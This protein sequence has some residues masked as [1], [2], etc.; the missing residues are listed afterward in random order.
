MT[1]CFWRASKHSESEISEG[2]SSRHAVDG[3]SDSIGGPKLRRHKDG[4]GPVTRTRPAFQRHT[5]GTRCC[6][7]A[8]SCL[9]RPSDGRS[10][11]RRNGF[12]ASWTSSGTHGTPQKKIG[13]DLQ[14]LRRHFSSVYCL[15][16][17][18]IWSGFL[19]ALSLLS[20]SLSL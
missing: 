8:R 3:I 16:R 4:Q 20:L 2:D 19:S 14:V 15:V 10:R 6:T 11:N 12:Q 9:R 18:R 13:T 7:P 5:H 17:V 1:Q